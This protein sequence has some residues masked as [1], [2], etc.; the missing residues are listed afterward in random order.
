M[1]FVAGTRGFAT[2]D[3]QGKVVL[4]NSRTGLWEAGMIR[5]LEQLK[6]ASNQVIYLGDTPISQYDVSM[7][8]QA[9]LDSVAHCSTPYEKSV[10]KTWI[11]EEAHIASLENVTWVDPTPWICS[12][13]PCTPIQG[14]Y[15]IF[16]DR[17]HL[18]ASFARTLERPFW[19]FL[20]GA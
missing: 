8:L 17:G 10:S 5:T 16:L 6:S 13:N 3:G 7:C 2:V 9:H 14:R 19:K 15:E 20:T 1:I 12:T 4:G 18:T 11:A